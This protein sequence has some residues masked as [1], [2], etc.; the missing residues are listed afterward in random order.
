ML[1]R[2]VDIAFALSVLFFII[3]FNFQDNRTGGWYQQWL[4]NLNGRSISDITFTD[5]LTGFAITPY[6]ALNDTAFVIKTTNG[7]DNWYINNI[8]TGQYSGFKRLAFLNT[9]TG[10]IVGNSGMY[11][12][13]NSGSNWIQI[14]KPNPFFIGLDISL[15]NSDTFFVCHYDSFD[16]GLFKTTNGGINWTRLYYETGSNPERIYMYN[17]RIGFMMTHNNLIMKTTNG[18][19]NWFEVLAGQG[20]TDIHFVDSLVGWKAYGD[21]KK[22]TNGGLNWLIQKLPTSNWISAMSKFSFVNRDTIWGVGGVIQWIIGTN[23][24]RGIVYRTTN[25]GNNWGYQIPDTSVDS[26]YF[27]NINFF[28]KKNGWVYY[29]INFHTNTGGNDTTIYMGINNNNNTILTDFILGQN[30]PNPFN[31]S[32]IIDVQCSTGGYITLKIFNILGKEITTLINKYLHPGSYKAKFD[33]GLLRQGYNLSTGIYF[34][35]LFVD[36]VRADTK[37]MILI[38]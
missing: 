31:Q 27:Q 24:F 11:K 8:F 32:S 1:K 20:Y 15:L 12:T 17:E 29:S 5:S 16:G 34:Y 7:G 23:H 30:Y 37:K 35:T 14:N 18:G 13:T 28:N 22:T 10:F 38:K 25:G 19:N 21:I 26:Y 6:V 36:G 2:I 33:A 4:P 9:N 3:A